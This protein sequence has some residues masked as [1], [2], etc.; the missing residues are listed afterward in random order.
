MIET[1]HTSFQMLNSDDDN[2]GLGISIQSHR[3]IYLI[4]V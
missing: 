2:E 4:V 3:A 1:W